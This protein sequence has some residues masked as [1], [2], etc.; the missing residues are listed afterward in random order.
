MPS[1][2]MD[3]R[4]RAEQDNRHIAS[5]LRA[6]LQHDA[7]GYKWDASMEPFH[8]SYDNW[9]IWGWRRAPPSSTHPPSPLSPNGFKG[10][11]DD[12]TAST[13]SSIASAEDPSSQL[14]VARVSRHAL[15]LE[16]EFKL[17]ERLGK[18]AGRDQSCYIKT[19]EFVRMPPR[20]PGDPKL[21][22]MISESP[23]R[24]YLIDMVEMG[25]NFYRAI[26]CNDTA[27]AQVERS[28]KPTEQRTSLHLFMQFAMGAVKCLEQLHHNDELVHGDLRGDAFHFNKETGVVRLINFG[29]GARS[30]ENGLTS[31]GWSSLTSQVGVEHKLQFIAPEQTGRM[32][33]EP[34]SRTDIYSLG[35]LFWTMLA[36]EPAFA[37]DKPLDIMQNVL[38]RRIPPIE[39]R[40]PDVPHIL[41]RIIQK[42]TQ[43]NMGDR[44]HSSSGLRYDLVQCNRF[45]EEGD[46]ENLKSFALGSRDISSAFNHP[47]Q[48]IG[49]QEQLDTIRRVLM[50]AFSRASQRSAIT[51]QELEILRSSSTF[52]SERLENGF[53][54]I[55][56]SESASTVST[57]I[58]KGSRA[59]IVDGN[60]P[61][62]SK[63]QDDGVQGSANLSS[64]DPPQ[65]GKVSHDAKTSHDSRVSTVSTDP[66][67][68][69]LNPS[70]SSVIHPSNSSHA[71]SSKDSLLRTAHKLRPQGKTEVVGISGQAGLGKSSILQLVQANAREKGYFASAKFDSL[72]KAPFESAFKVMSSLFRQIFTEGD[73][74]TEFHQQLRTLLRPIWGSLH[75]A[76]ELPPWLISPNVHQAKMNL[77]DGS[78]NPYGIFAKAGDNGNTAS[79]WMHAGGVVRDRRFIHTFLDF[80]RLLCMH[81]FLCFCLDDLQFADE[82]SLD[83]IHTIINARIPLVMILTFRT[84]EALPVKIRNVLKQ[85]TNVE[86]KPFTEEQTSQYVAQ[87][88]HRSPHYVLPLVAVIQQKTEG[89]PFFIR[90]IMDRLH[91]SKCIFYSWR[92]SQWEYDIDAIFNQLAESGNE[93]FASSDSLLKR[94]DDIPQD[95][96]SL[97]CWASLMG[98][99][100]K[101]S[102]LNRVMVCDCSKSSPPQLLPPRVKDCVGGLQSALASFAIMATDEEDKFR[103]SHDRYMGAAENLRTSYD[104]KEMHYVLACAMM[105]HDPWNNSRPT[106]VLFNQSR[107]IC[108]AIDVVRKRAPVFKP[109][110]QLLYEA[111]ETAR[112]QGARQVALYFLK[113]A[114]ALLAEDVWDTTDKRADTTYIEVLTLMTQTAGSYWFQGDFESANTIINEIFDHTEDPSDRSAAFMIQSRIYAQQGDGIAAYQSMSQALSDLGHK[115]EPKTWEQCDVEF[116][117]I[118]PLL[119]GNEPDLTIDL[120]H[121]DNYLITTGAVM[122]ELVSTAF[123]TNPLLFYQISLELVD[124]YLKKGIFPQLALGYI[125]LGSIAIGRFDMTE[126]GLNLGQTAKL[127]MNAFPQEAYT[128]GR[129]LTLHSLFLGHMEADVTEQLPLLQ[130]GLEA[131]IAAGDK[132][133]QTLNTGVSAA[134]RV[135]SSQELSEVETFVLDQDELIPGW[136]DDLR[137]GIFLTAVLQYARALQGKTDYRTPEF[138]MDDEHHSTE[139]YT[140]LVQGKASEPSRPMT[141]YNSYRLAVLYR[142]GHYDEALQLGE[143]LL[144]SLDSLF[145]MRYNYFARFFLALTLIEKARSGIDGRDCPQLLEKVR[146]IQRKL[147]SCRLSIDGNNFTAHANLLEAAIAEFEQR[148]DACITLYEA[149]VNHS[150][151]HG[152]AMDEALANELYAEFLIRRGCT[153][154]AR[155]L[156]D[157]AV[158]AYRRVGALGKVEQI[159]EKH[160]FTIHR[161]HAVATAEQGTQ[162]TEINTGNS[163]YKLSRNE[164]DLISQTSEDRTKAWLNPVVT[165]PISNVRDIG[166]PDHD[167]HNGLSAV[168][169]DMIDLATILESSQ[170]L[171]SELDVEKLLKSLTGIIVDASGAE[172]GGVVVENEDIGWSLAAL[173]GPEGDIVEGVGQPLLNIP[174]AVTQQISLYCLRFRESLFVANVLEDERFSV[175]KK[176]RRGNPEGRAFIALP[177]LHGDNHLLGCIYIEG[178]ARSFT[179]RN[180]AVLRLLVNQVS[181]SIANAMLFKR[182]EK[183]SATNAAMLEIQKQALAQARGAERKAKEA[184]AKAMEMVRLKEEAAKVKSMFLANV[185]HELRTPLN[186]VIGMSE[187]LK[188]S[189]LSKEQ[190]GYADSIRVCADTLLSVIND[191]LDFSKLEAGKMQMFNVQLSLKETISE[192]V[193]ALSY[194]N[195]ERGLQTVEELEIDSAMLVMGDPVRLHQVFMN[196]LSNAY[197]FTAKGKVTVKAVLEREDDTTIQVLCSVSDTGIGISEEQS[198]KLFLPFSQADSST[199]R[200]YGGTG[201]GLSICKA[202]IE[203][204]K[205]RIW[206]ESETGVGTT[207]SFRLTFQKVDRNVLSDAATPAKT[208]DPMSIY[209]I[210]TADASDPSADHHISLHG[211]P[212]DQL[213]VCIAEDNPINQKIAISFVERLGFKCAAF[214]DGQQAVDALVAA[215]AEGSPFHLVLMDCQMPVLDGYNATREIRK[216]P[217]PAVSGVLVIAMTASAIRGDREKC[218]EAGMNNYLAKPVRANVLKHM[219]EGYL[220]AGDKEVANLQGVADGIAKEVLDGVKESGGEVAKK[221]RR[222]LTQQASSSSST[223]TVVP[224]RTKKDDQ[225]GLVDGV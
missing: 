3:E 189:E 220:A 190:E 141:I 168:G 87:I 219:L 148:F 212:R 217:D 80:L 91:K 36:D 150:V 44:Y 62:A 8:S 138:V 120:S 76:L 209:R 103:F 191:I 202:I 92:S 118:A 81:K 197:K 78:D 216:H 100:F 111:A 195:I 211:I 9:H 75:T 128:N 145:S 181:I 25:P 35:V 109:F 52:S 20:V 167:D 139:D 166:R 30:F 77:A 192:V 129:G 61:S 86:L 213:K 43:K 88:L 96:R 151:L 176:Y 72:K 140:E 50:R 67:S 58:S 48:L 10:S 33:A 45:L 59:S 54:D 37:G 214:P 221:K 119:A 134:Y 15:R 6:R 70:S 11:D 173:R 83:L 68:P 160:A 194:A 225:E 94:L 161:T 55:A 49:R 172:Y 146:V 175:S 19:I 57:K 63:A 177:I 29:S 71:A 171:S 110:R 124:L 31:A 7:P 60:S 144:K 12:D 135:W 18:D 193:R 130:R 156:I 132:I 90:E 47:S 14:V 99:S 187:L 117:R 224:D 82:E 127:V 123:W 112:E 188:A 23:G 5:R 136:R 114:L 74:T 210:A 2:D 73:V 153:R 223:A 34:D 122:V 206:L 200:S 53:M 65:D 170:L 56:Q 98:S 203:I 101:F 89:I 46:A 163:H 4:T 1:T 64:S 196:L 17:A 69:A 66:I 159:A 95:A 180:T 51:K 164:E 97:L 116:R 39:S 182:L 179:E 137:G 38:S 169:L 85:A 142:F 147:D 149:A 222:Q 186:G 41:S 32:P 152:I 155:N 107:H 162:T 108:A 13:Q 21:V 205:G 174:D 185:S 105:K 125:H 126:F 133:L 131:T 157:D 42:M 201:L 40:R 16:R 27:A 113:Y 184:E 158:A 26:T 218:L 28:E 22:A 121:I 215:S 165:I 93:D 204:M 207:V 102:L 115:L 199:A 104:E 208:V 24:N 84:E 143:S 79:D 183:A 154:P 106:Q 198:K 178:P